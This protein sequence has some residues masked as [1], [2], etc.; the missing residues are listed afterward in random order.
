MR[1]AEAQVRNIKPVA[2]DY[3]NVKR[4]ASRKRKMANK[5]LVEKEKAI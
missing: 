5:V 3:A 4:S 2:T 1:R